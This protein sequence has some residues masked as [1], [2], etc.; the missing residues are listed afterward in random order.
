[1]P[2]NNQNT[3]AG[4]KA[5]LTAMGLVCSLPCLAVAAGQAVRRSIEEK[6]VSGHVRDFGVR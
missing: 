6:A 5:M 2:D 1:M 4:P 3:M